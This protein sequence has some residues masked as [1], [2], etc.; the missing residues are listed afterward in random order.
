M[1]EIDLQQLLLGRSPKENFSIA[2][3]N[4]AEIQE[5]LESITGVA[6]GVCDTTPGVGNVNVV[7]I[8]DFTLNTGVAVLIKF[9][10][11][12]IGGTSNN[13]MNISGSGAKPIKMNDGSTPSNPVYLCP[14]NGYVFFVYDGTSW[15]WM[16]SKTNLF[17]YPITFKD[18]I[19]LL[20][21]LYIKGTGTGKTKIVFNNNTSND[22]EIS[23]PAK[24]GRVILDTDVINNLNSTDSNMPLSANMG[25]AL[26][27]KLNGQQYG[28]VWNQISDM[29]AQLNAESA[30][31]QDVKIGFNFYI[32][33]ID[34]PD[35]WVAQIHSTKII[36]TYTDDQTFVNDIKTNKTIRVGFYTISL[37]ETAKVDL[38]NYV[39]MDRTI[40]G[41][42]LQNNISKEQLQ[43]ALEL[44][45]AAYR[46]VS[47]FAT[48]A[49]GIKAD[50]AVPNT[51]KI[52]GK[53]LNA[54]ITLTPGDIGAAPSVHTH[55][56]IVN[57]TASDSRWS[58]TSGNFIL[59]VSADSDMYPTDVYRKNGS[60]YEK[61]IVGF[62]KKTS[63]VEIE[64]FDK[65]EGYLILDK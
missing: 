46:P 35:F 64:S 14:Q 49:Q 8:P 15:V 32:I 55:K 10:K 63:T 56:S 9:T 50:N 34:V 44:G 19:T 22:Y 61:V 33:D 16:N 37:L 39:Q 65:F 47:D 42:S 12:F 27:D 36:Y 31:A 13:T 38:S 45:S 1:K 21:N 53:Q 43:T 51:R 4:F 58:G 18:D 2:N 48:A 17:D 24:S 20:K 3:E 54:D 41:I 25:K 40:A 5:A 30:P 6:F 29:V 60:L 23:L 26:N 7:N 52:N 28:V 62:N 59:T 57:F 11:G